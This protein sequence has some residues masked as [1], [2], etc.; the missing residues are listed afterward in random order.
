MDFFKRTVIFIV[1]FVIAFILYKKQLIYKEKFENNNNSDKEAE[2]PPYI[3]NANKAIFA[4]NF[5]IFS[6]SPFL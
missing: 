4:F 2:R 3:P 6:S 5:L 1:L